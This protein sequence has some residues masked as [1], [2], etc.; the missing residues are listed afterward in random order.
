M[1]L[2][3]TYHIRLGVELDIELDRLV[4]L[5]DFDRPDLIRRGLKAGLPIVEERYGM[6]VSPVREITGKHLGLSTLCMKPKRKTVQKK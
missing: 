2:S 4:T 6:A 3:Q 5:T 1:S